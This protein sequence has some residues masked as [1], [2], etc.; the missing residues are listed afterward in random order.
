MRGRRSTFLLVLLML[1]CSVFAREKRKTNA[2]FCT[3]AVNGA[4]YLQGFPPLI[5]PRAETVFAE[6]SFAGKTVEEVRLRQFHPNHEVE[7][8]YKF[9]T[10][11]RLTALLGSVAKWGEWVG[12]TNLYPDADGTVGSFHVKYYKPGTQDLIAYPED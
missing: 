5:N 10:G 1:S 11:G 2:V 9:D 6:I 12:E 7:F 4:W 8:D 3:R